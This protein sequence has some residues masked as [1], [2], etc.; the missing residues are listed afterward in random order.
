MEKVRHHVPV[1][2][3]VWEV[4]E[5][6]G[7]SEGLV[8]AEIELDWTEEPFQTPEWLGDEVSGDPRYLNAQLS[9]KPYGSWGA[10]D[11]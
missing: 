8:V 10:A 7:A 9:L 5:F 3:H 6:L 1:G 4:D 11:V 2:G